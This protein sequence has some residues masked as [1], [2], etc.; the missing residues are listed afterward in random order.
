MTAAVITAIYADYDVLQPAGDEPGVEWVCVTDNQSLVNDPRGWHV[1]Y[2]P[3][4]DVHPNRAAK[5]PKMLP[6]CY[7]GADESVWIDASFAVTSPTFVRDVL[8]Y[9]DPI[10]Q[11]LHPDRDC[12]YQE[13]AFSLPLPKYRG[14]QIAEQMAHYRAVGHPERWGLWATGVIARKH[15]DAV[16]DF[17]WRWLADCEC[18]TYQDQLSHAP[19]LRAAGLRPTTLPG[20]FVESPWLDYRASG[21]H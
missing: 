18:F 3:R 17:G 2:E 8:Q 14:E 9:A 11:F 15:T 10:A 13:A 16:I 21:R 7:T 4:H 19:A 20:H 12:I 6:W 5:R 1:I